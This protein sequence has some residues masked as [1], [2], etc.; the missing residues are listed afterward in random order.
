LVK[1]IQVVG[2]QVNWRLLSVGNVLDSVAGI[3]IIGRIGSILNIRIGLLGVRA[4]RIG[5]IYLRLLVGVLRRVR[6]TIRVVML[7]IRIHF[8]EGGGGPVLFC[9]IFNF[10]LFLFLCYA[11]FIRHVRSE[12]RN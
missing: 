3:G 12:M 1:S 10:K 7:I 5:I 6:F 11:G 9:T 2:W 4:L 8:V